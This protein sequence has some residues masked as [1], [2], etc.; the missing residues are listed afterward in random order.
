VTA[1]RSWNYT[2]R[3]IIDHGAP[4]MTGDDLM[5][6]IVVNRMELSI[7]HIWQSSSGL[8]GVMKIT[9]FISVLIFSMAL[10]SVWAGTNSLDNYKTLTLLNGDWMLAPADAQEG[11]ATKK[12]RRQNLLVQMKLRSASR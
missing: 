3:Y 11:G 12:G 6:R 7:F 8:G 10:S 1:G 5:P 2:N 9:R 4:G